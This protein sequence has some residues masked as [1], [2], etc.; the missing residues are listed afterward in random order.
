MQDALATLEDRLASPSA[1]PDWR[2]EVGKALSALSASFVDHVAEVEAEEGLLAAVVEDV[3]RLAPAVDRLQREHG[4][5]TNTILALAGVLEAA[6][7]D[8]IR[9]SGLELMR[10]VVVHRQRGSDLVYEAY[11]TDIGGQSGS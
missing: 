6:D 1:S 10:A 11:A 4:E 2:T 5:I 3:P 9:E 8:S 7:V